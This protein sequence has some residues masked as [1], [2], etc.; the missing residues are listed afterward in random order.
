MTSMIKI[1]EG[2][3]GERS[4]VLPP[5]VVEQEENDPLA[6]SLYITDIGYYPSAR[7]HHRC[8]EEGID[9]YVLIYCVDGSG[10]YTLHGTRH[11]VG[12]DQYFILPSGVPHAYG[13]VEDGKWTIYW[14]HFRGEH[15]AIYSEGAQQPQ[16]I[17]TALNSRIN[18]RNNI[19]EEIFSTL[20]FGEGIEDLR[21]AS[22]LLHHYLASLRYLRQFRTTSRLGA[23]Q[24]PFEKGKE[25]EV[26]EAAI[27]YMSEHIE[28]RVTMKDLA[29][30]VGYS[31][32][33]F[34]SLFRQQTGI[35]PL[36]YFN[37]MKID[38]ACQLLEQTD[39]HIN[40]ICFKV[41]FDDSLYFSRLFSKTTGMAPKA[42][43]ERKRKG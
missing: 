33:H 27:H 38:H 8:R 5:S 32:S 2:F 26:V 41:G 37:K 43:R 20:H 9:Q 30:Y 19:F 10:W 3:Q 40:Q 42:Y 14:V 7:H 34:S 22:S 1:K 23:P 17:N 4:V 29:N 39:L 12:K 16:S 11:E 24:H 31:T 18:D 36:A 35:S 21:Y 25:V 13:A 6:S 28:R 15:A